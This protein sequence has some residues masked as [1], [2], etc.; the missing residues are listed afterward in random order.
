M[1]RCVH[2][3]QSDDSELLAQ[4]QQ[5][6]CSGKMSNFDYLSFLNARAGRTVNDLTQYPVFPWVLSDYTSAELDQSTLGLRRT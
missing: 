5:Q 6:W 1:T 4:T 3:A 2:R